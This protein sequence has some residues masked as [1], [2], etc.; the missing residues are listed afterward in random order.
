MAIST[1]KIPYPA[2]LDLA[3]TPTPLEPLSRLG[4]KFGVEMHVKR[5]DLTALGGG[6]NA[7]VVADWI[8][9]GAEYPPPL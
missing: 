2:R 3:R 7:R 1:K 4:E 8:D 6:G 9:V 5:D